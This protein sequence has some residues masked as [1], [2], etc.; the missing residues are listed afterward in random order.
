MIRKLQ[1]EPSAAESL[2]PSSNRFSFVNNVAGTNPSNIEVTFPEA[3]EAS[4]KALFT[5]TETTTAPSLA[6]KEAD[7]LKRMME[8]ALLKKKKKAEAAVEAAAAQIVV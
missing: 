6:T 7:V 1:G 3:S 5:S 8:A 4:K 2:N